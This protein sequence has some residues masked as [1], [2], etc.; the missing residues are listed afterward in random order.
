MR[1]RDLDGMS[2]LRELKVRGARTRVLFLSFD[3]EPEW[4]T[5]R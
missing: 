3:E 5:V 4:C 1:M 2:V